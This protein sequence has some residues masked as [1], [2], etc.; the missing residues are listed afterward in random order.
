MAGGHSDYTHGTMKVD[1]QS[2]TFSGFM[3]GTKYG[4]SAIALIVILPTLIFGVG[5]AYFPALIATLIVGFLIGL[6][7]KLKGGWYVGMVGA[8]V[9][10]TVLVGLGALLISLVA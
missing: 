8:A 4:G 5:M 10:T 2:G 9:L 6:G 1:A 7:L 3:G